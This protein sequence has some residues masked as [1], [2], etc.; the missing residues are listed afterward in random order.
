MK[1]NQNKQLPAQGEWMQD[2]QTL[3]QLHQVGWEK[4]KPLMV[5]KFTLL[6]KPDYSKGL[7]SHDAV[8]EAKKLKCAHDNTYG[9]GINP[10]A[11]PTVIEEGDYLIHYVET[12]LPEKWAKEKWFV[13]FKKA[14]KKSE[15]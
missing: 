1:D 11:V 2:N 10:E 7:T 4:G 8:K 13:N 6:V 3:Y 9:K 14:I 12:Y 15:L 5:N